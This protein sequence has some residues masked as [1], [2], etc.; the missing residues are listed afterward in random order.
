MN[1]RDRYESDDDEFY[2]HPPIP[3]GQVAQGSTPRL[4]PQVQQLPDP[5]ARISTSSSSNDYVYPRI[6]HPPIRLN[7][8]GHIHTVY[9]WDSDQG[10]YIL[11]P[12]DWTTSSESERTPCTTSDEFHEY[13]RY[14]GNR[15]TDS[16]LQ[17][18]L[19][20]HCDRSSNSY[21]SSSSSSEYMVTK[22]GRIVR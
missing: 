14:V 10:K 11:E 5:R 22:D 9:S 20:R 18:W 17:S 12:T 1:R 15:D 7:H 2:H 6:N 8:H 13:R 4:P 16:E 19:N 21:T 3:S